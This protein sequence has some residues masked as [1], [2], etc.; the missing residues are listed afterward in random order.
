MLLLCTVLT[1]TLSAISYGGQKNKLFL[2]DGTTIEGEI[3]SF[4]NG[5]Y[6]VDTTDQGQ[7]RIGASKIRKMEMIETAEPPPPAPVFSETTDTSM[8][9]QIDKVTATIANNPQMTSQVAA[10]AS[11]PAIQ[12]LMNDPEIV[13]AVKAGD[14]K[15]LMSNQK[16]MELV[17]NQKIKELSE[18][19]K[20]QKSQ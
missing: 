2:L 4:L 18:K 8:K 12:S 16:F 3:I 11:D 5:V 7:V 13:A 15:A 20:E 6:T 14:I 17:N 1:L 9:P 10:L 19:V